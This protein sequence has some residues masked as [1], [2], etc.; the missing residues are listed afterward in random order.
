MRIYKKE[1]GDRYRIVWALRRYLEHLP[2][3]NIRGVIHVSKFNGYGWASLPDQAKPSHKVE[4]GNCFSENR[5][6]RLLLKPHTLKAS[7]T[8]SPPPHVP[9]FCLQLLS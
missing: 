4:K 1:C 7:V 3:S 9:H 5:H 8:S 6:I 2:T